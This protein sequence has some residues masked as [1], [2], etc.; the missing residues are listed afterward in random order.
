M[1]G[2][3]MAA[4]APALAAALLLAGCTQPL[5]QRSPVGEVADYEA[6]YKLDP[7]GHTLSAEVTARWAPAELDTFFFLLHRDLQVAEAGTERG[8][9]GELL[10]LAEGKSI[11]IRMR[12]HLPDTSW[13]DDGGHLALYALPVA[14]TADTVALR[15]SYTGVIHDEVEVPEF[16]RWE[17]ADETTGLID[18]R[19]AFL[20]PGTGYYPALPGAYHLSRFTTTIEHP[21]EWE[22]LVEGNLL[23]REPGRARFDSAHPL[24][25][26]YLV[27]GPYVLST[28]EDSSFTVAM[29]HY[30]NDEQLAERY[31]DASANYLADYEELIGPYPFERFSVVENWF[32]TGYGMASYTLL[33]SQVLRLPFIIYTSLGHEVCHNWWGNGV[34]VDYERGNWCEGLTTYQADYRFKLERSAGEAKQYR[35]DLLRDYS[36]YVIRGDEQ[37]FP[38]REFTSRTT[39]GTRTIGYGKAMMVF[40]MIERRIGTEEFESALRDLYYERRFRLTGWRHFFER[41][42]EAEGTDLDWY[43]RQWIDDDGAPMFEVANELVHHAGDGSGYLLEF[44]L[45]QVQ[46]ARPFRLDV[47]IR[48]HFASDSTAEHVLRDVNGETYHARVPAGARPVRFDVD[49]DFHVFR[50]L[51]PAEA[52][53]TLSGF[54]AADEPVVVLPTGGTQAMRDA[55]REFAEALF[56]R[57]DARYVREDS[58]ELFDPGERS[59]LRFGNEHGARRVLETP[60]ADGLSVRNSALALAWASRSADDPTVVNMQ[61]WAASP[62]ALDQLPR[63]LP[64]YGKYSYLAFSAGENVAKG[65]W[66][67]TQS[68][69]IVELPD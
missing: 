51:D 49:P 52:P 29:Y 28:R 4:L 13:F 58:L 65:Q 26:S 11:P 63:K 33:G 56:R 67:V 36:D 43:E 15:F 31:L 46:D 34:L 5:P 25:G 42:A 3:L 64:H 68:P 18:E 35:L 8:A 59:L 62:H 16:S 2:R 38:L 27:A 50:A 55:Y 30:G 1:N 45:R 47:P 60:E 12:P 39:A 48:L 20:V 14:S 57:T 19:G 21:D 23:A 32:P 69:L 10:A 24:D 54:Y 53:P 6:V 66:P 7:E 40:H 44:D 37:D 9:H 17:I 41:F 61:V 22:A